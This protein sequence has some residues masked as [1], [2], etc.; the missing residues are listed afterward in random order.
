MS[1]YFENTNRNNISTMNFHPDS[2]MKWNGDGTSTHT[3]IYTDT[4]HRSP[5]KVIGF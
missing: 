1:P 2:Y 3:Q 4:K 5:N